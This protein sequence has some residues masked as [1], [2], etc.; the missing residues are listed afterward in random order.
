MCEFYHCEILSS[1]CKISFAHISFHLGVKI[2]HRRQKECKYEPECWD[3]TLFQTTDQF[4]SL[5]NYVETNS[6]ARHNFEDAARNY[7]ILGRRVRN[8]G[9]LVMFY[10][11]FLPVEG[12]GSGRKNARNEHL[13]MNG[14]NQNSLDF[15]IMG[16][17][18]DGG[19]LVTDGLLTRTGKKLFGRKGPWK[20][21][22]LAIWKKET[23]NVPA[24]YCPVSL[25]SIINKIYT[26]HLYWKRI[27]EAG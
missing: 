10:F 9:T 11:P 25:A 24:R 19:L 12:L 2:Q 18:S 27:P 22:C 6:I 23:K 3:V 26:R 8:L 1:L 17:I 14:A 21:I 15:L 13:A 4:F 5:L 16:H 7:K 20:S